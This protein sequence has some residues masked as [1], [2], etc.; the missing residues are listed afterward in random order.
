MLTAIKKFFTE[1]IAVD[2]STDIEHQLK[3]ATAALMIEMMQQDD[4][5]HEA[6]EDAVKQALQKK[7]SLADEETE[8]L[9][10]LAHAELKQS[11]D[12]YQF[13]SLINQNF[14]PQQKYKVIE[15]L[16]EIAYADGHLDRYEEHMVRRIA[17]LIYVPHSDF[18]RAKHSAMPQ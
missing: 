16:W 6:E 8:T 17:E 3:L 11:A 7:F 9:F 1:N 5:A 10:T 15:Y 2:N 13:T 18:I 12:Y 14:N 4:V